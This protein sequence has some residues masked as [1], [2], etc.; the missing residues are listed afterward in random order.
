MRPAGYRMPRRWWAWELLRRIGD[1]LSTPGYWLAEWA[2]RR[3]ADLVAADDQRRSI[4]RL[5]QEV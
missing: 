3:K 2:D 5:L 1:A 4:T